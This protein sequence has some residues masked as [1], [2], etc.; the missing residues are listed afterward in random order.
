[1]PSK[2]R[3][4]EEPESN[5]NEESI[6]RTRAEG[7]ACAAPA[8]ANQEDDAWEDASSSEN[9]DEGVV[10]EPYNHDGSDEEVVED[11]AEGGEE[12]EADPQY[13]E[14]SK[15]AAKIADQFQTLKME[16][17]KDDDAGAEEAACVW[18]PDRG[19]QVG[20]GEQ[21]GYSCKAYD[22]FFQLR[23]EYPALSFDILCDQEGLART[24]YPL[25]L[26]LV[27]GS[28]ADAS[29]Q[30]LLYVLKV[31]NLCR[32]KHDTVDEEEEED[33]DGSESDDEHGGEEVE[34]R[35]EENNGEP[36]VAHRAIPH[37]GTINR[38]RCSHHQP[39]LVATWSDLGCVQVFDVADELLAVSDSTAWAKEHAENFNQPSKPALCFTSSSTTHVC[40]GYGLDWSSTVPNV[41]AS[42]DCQGV[43]VLW[44]PTEAGRW[45]PS[46]TDATGKSVEEIQWSPTQRD[47]FIAA[48]VGGTVEVWDAR[49]LRKPRL[50]W[51]ADP[52]DINV[53]DWNQSTA[54]SHLLVTGSDSGIVAVWD[55][56]T[57]QQA[58]VAPI[59]RL[60]F[61]SSS[62]ITSV[63]FST[64]NESVL[65]V[66]ADDGQCTLWDLSLERDPDEERNVLGDNF[67][68]GDVS[69]LPDQLMFQHQGLEH[70]KEV[71]FHSQIP[72]LVV[73]TDF[74]GMHLFK[75]VNWRSLMK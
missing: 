6:K 63:E 42:G 57:V 14:F 64:H 24:K 60:D 32:T 47:V 71:H 43:L 10:D 58:Q 7:Q 45:A 37:H 36:L 48:R 23:T 27:A 61:H 55:L 4:S 3:Q 28:Q 49:T 72:G 9:N 68:R 70:P 2:K 46:G 38:L 69:Q 15:E 18:R 75:P 19:D 67:G 51:K 21:L 52:Q 59:Q 74:L 56:R 50:S 12:G 31:S 22:A 30:N 20:E 65:A 33:S 16:D 25:S 1:M 73:T 8:T 26:C 5:E 62:R 53:A 41:F 29:N 54:S 13:D 66:A 39:S 40:E 17:L 35:E 34:E 44:H 11:K